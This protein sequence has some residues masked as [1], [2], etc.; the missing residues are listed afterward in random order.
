[1]EDLP[2]GDEGR[3]AAAPVLDEEEAFDLLVA[4]CPSFLGAAELDAYL[5]AFEEADE[6]DRYVRTSALAHHLV[7]RLEAGRTE[8]VAAVGGA[9]EL[10]LTTGDDDAVELVRMGLFEYLQN[11]CSHDD[12][13]VDADLVPPLL[14]PAGRQAWHEVDELWVEAGRWADEAG[15]V[16]LAEYGAVLDP[17]L[18]RYLQSSKR[19]LPDGMLISATDLVRYQTM[20]RDISPLA[21]AGYG[22]VRWPLVVGGVA[23]L[24][25]ALVLLVR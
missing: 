25:A 17:N 1:M 18:R 8:E 3:P 23:L 4:A 20:L 11:I 14:G 24:V 9:A 22:R 13:L 19:R 15:K 21:P 10:V 7:G 2:G 16:T 6:P 5:D 12:V